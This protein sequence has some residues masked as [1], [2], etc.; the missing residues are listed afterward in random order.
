MSAHLAAHS[1]KS[2]Q[3]L[4]KVLATSFVR[5]KLEC[6]SA[7]LLLNDPVPVAY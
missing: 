6:S 3:L 5:M 2:F 7:I 4:E 1:F